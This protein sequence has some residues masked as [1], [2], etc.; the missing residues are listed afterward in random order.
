MRKLESD[1]LYL[2]GRLQVATARD[3]LKTTGINRDAVKFLTTVL[4]V[5]EML[6]PDESQ[7]GL[8]LFTKGD[9]VKQTKTDLVISLELIDEGYAKNFPGVE[10][11]RGLLE[12]L[13]E[14]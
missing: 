7:D 1:E 3:A 5:H 4:D 11:A 12:I 8:V 13:R 2:K 9:T 6:N 14:T 10:A